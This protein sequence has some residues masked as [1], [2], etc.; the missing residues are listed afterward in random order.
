MKDKSGTLQVTGTGNI[1]VAPDEAVVHLRVITEGRTAAEAVASAAKQTDAVIKAASAQPN[2]GVTTTGLGVSPIVKYDAQTRVPT[3]VGF[4]ATNGVEVK[5]KI[6]YAGQVFDAGVNAGANQSSGI[7]FR[8][9]DEAPFR[10]DALCLAV[11]MAYKEARLVAKAADV[12]LDGPETIEI[13]P[14]AFRPFMRTQAFEAA[15]AAP[16]TPVIPED[17]TI[18][19]SVK[20]LFRTKD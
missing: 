9:Q 11:M 6:A 17:L 10:E 8:L 4:R 2:H 19:A 16:V 15:A 7:S 20:I 18:S 5:T 12:E 13:D 14:G 1:K 3:I